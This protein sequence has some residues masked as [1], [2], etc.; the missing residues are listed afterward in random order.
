MEY[1]GDHTALVAKN[2]ELELRCKALQETVRM[3]GQFAD[4]ANVLASVVELPKLTAALLPTLLAATQAKAIAFCLRDERG[5]FQVLTSQGI[6]ITPVGRQYIQTLAARASERND[7]VTTGRTAGEGLSLAHQEASLPVTY[8]AIPCIYEGASNSVLIFAATEL[9]TIETLSFITALSPNIGLSVNNASSFDTITKTTEALDGE[10]NRLNAV[11][12]N[13]ADGLLVTDTDGVIIRANR[14]LLE[15]FRY[16]K[17]RMAGRMA[18]DVFVPELAGLIATCKKSGKREAISLEIELPGDRIA[19]ALATALTQETTLSNERT[20]GPAIVATGV[21]I[22]IRD[23]TREKEVDRMKTDFLSTVSH[24]LRTPLTS[25]LG[26]AR[27][28]KKKMHDV[29]LPHV[30]DSNAKIHKNVQQVNDNIDIIVSEGERLT[31]LINDVLDLAKMEAGKIE[32]KMEPLSVVDVVEHATATLSSLLEQ[33]GLVL[34]LDR[35]TGLPLVIGDKNRLMQVVINLVSNAIKFTDAGSITC[36]VARR[37]AGV[38]ICVQDT[39]TGIAPADLPLIFDKFKQVGDTL[40]NKPKG[41]GLGLP[42]CREIVLRHG[43]RIW[44]ESKPGKGSSFFFTLPADIPADTSM[45]TMNID[46]FV[47]HLKHHV[48]ALPES[49]EG[50]KK[51]LVVDDELHIRELLRQE[52]ESQ[53]YSV[54][55]AKTGIEAVLQAK[56]VNPDLIILDVMMPGINGFDV[57]AVLKNDPATSKIPIIIHSV[58]DDVERGY[59]IGVDRY[60]KKP[61]DTEELLLN[62]NDLLSRGASHKKVFVVDEDESLVKTLSETLRMRG[63]HVVGLCDGKE[64]IEKAQAEKPDMIIIDRVFSDR[65]NIIKTLKFEKNL[66]NI[67]FVIIG[68]QAPGVSV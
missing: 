3:Q 25:V 56:T 27:I 52:L 9:F 45:H 51:I 7:I 55:E 36:S 60:L 63:F 32:W 50:G 37:G 39:G 48:T 40:T 10:R 44:A 1:A 20:G 33:K 64:C 17:E 67:Y 30:K 18:S 59:R 41:T 62:I 68:G 11:M 49:P 12:Y 66:R 14:A 57:A 38:V 46:A 53:A 43:G 16:G 15:M 6:E 65:H 31:A 34:Q 42:I 24:E 35:E 4:I 54:H 19:K 61:V 5:V 2:R 26:F 47:S 29:I 28:I 21:V 13:M 23:I 58:V 8:A 22:I